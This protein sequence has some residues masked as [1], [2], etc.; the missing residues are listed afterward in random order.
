MELDRRTLLGAIGISMLGGFGVVG[1]TASNDT[2]NSA[3]STAAAATQSVSFDGAAWSYDETNDVYYQIGRSYA[4][5]PAAP[6]YETLGIYVPGAYLTAAQNSDGTY[7]GTVNASGV[8][9]DY[10]ASTAPIVFPVNTP[11]YAAQQPPSSYTYDD[12]SSFMEAGMVYVAVGL[13]GKDSNT[14]SYS[15]NAPWGVTDL[16]AAV[17]YLRYNA[18]VVPGDKDA[19]FVFGHSG[20]GAQS[21]VMGS[22]GDS[23]LYTPYL[24]AIGAATS[25]ANGSTISDAIAGAM[26]W[27]PITSLDYANAAYEWNMGQFATTG[28]RTPGT[29]TAAYSSDLAAAFATYVNALGLKDASGTK[30]SLSESASGTYL[31]GTYFD[32]VMAVIESSLNNFLSDTT[33]PYTPSST[34]M[35]GMG[36]GTSDASGERPSGAPSGGSMP[37]GGAPSDGTT[38]GDSADG[39]QSSA[40]ATT[41]DTVADYISY[42]NAD[43]T[44]VEYDA[45]SNTVKVTS[46]EGFVNSQ[47]SPSKDVGAFDAPDRSATENLVLGLNTVSLHFAQLSKDVIEAHES[48]YSS[49]TNWTSEYG[50]AEY[51]SDFAKTDSVGSAVASR[52]DMYNPMYYLSDFYAGNETSTVAPHWRIRT[53]IMQG[54]TASTVEINL[55]LALANHGIDDIDFATVWGQG[56]TMAERTGDGTTNFIAWVKQSVG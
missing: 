5:N 51:T 39:S 2:T 40:T 18:D 21:A 17:R 8:A 53:G 42:L 25:D 30:L 22:S 54:D 32:H 48:T 19:M 13:R 31:S 20:G 15:G 41:Y 52:V 33:F 38:P 10:T 28:T 29:W 44:W 12:V 11:G 23:E 6:D 49:L 27:C 3:S 16:K 35:A 37:S 9:G 56:H 1:C 47:K 36:T 50:A 24:E 34:T 4:A 7:T 45:G 43:S 26:C 46:L 55:A 14:D